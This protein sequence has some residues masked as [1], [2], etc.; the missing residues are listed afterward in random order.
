[1]QSH[2]TTPTHTETVALVLTLNITETLASTLTETLTETV[3][4]HRKLR[5]FQ[6][7]ESTR[8]HAKTL[9]DL[10][11]RPDE[12][13]PALMRKT[14]LFHEQTIASSQGTPGVS[15]SGEVCSRYGR[16]ERRRQAGRHL[17]R[18]SFEHLFLFGHSSRKIQRRK[19]LTAVAP[20]AQCRLRSSPQY[21]D[22]CIWVAIYSPAYG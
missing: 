16:Q 18:I 14:R 11:I 19:K 9:A 5:E 1:M 12:S 17:W 8:T 7:G 22:F 10:I 2:T 13:R 4:A 3:I 21:L 20:N 6:N 15:A